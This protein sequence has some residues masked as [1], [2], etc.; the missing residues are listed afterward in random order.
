MLPL[1]VGYRVGI[2]GKEQ[3]LAGCGV[4]QDGE[5]EIHEDGGA[6]ETRP[7]PDHTVSALTFH[8]S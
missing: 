7:D 2:L 1:V 4:G 3:P 6:E 5:T 8:A